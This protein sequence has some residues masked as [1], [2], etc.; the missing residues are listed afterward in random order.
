M[1]NPCPFKPSEFKALIPNGSQPFC[2]IFRNFLKLFTLIWQFF[3][4]MVSEDGGPTQDFLVWIGVPATNEYEES[5]VPAAVMSLDASDSYEGCIRLTWRN[6]F[7]ATYFRVKRGTTNVADDATEIAGWAE[8]KDTFVDSEAI[9]SFF[10]ETDYYYWVQVKNAAGESPWSESALGSALE[11]STDMVGITNGKTIVQLAIQT[12][13]VIDFV[14]WGGGGAGGAGT[15]DVTEHYYSATITRLFKTP[16]TGGSGASGGYGYVR[17][18]AVSA[19]DVI[20][21]KRGL[22]GSP[23]EGVGGLNGGIGGNTEFQIHRS[24]EPTTKTM[25]VIS[26]GGGGEATIADKS[27]NRVDIALLGEGGS[28]FDNQTP[29]GSFSCQKGSVGNNGLIGTNAVCAGAPAI[30]DT[31]FNTGAYGA[32]GASLGGNLKPSYGENGMVFYA[33]RGGATA[34]PTE[35]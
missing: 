10:A 22:G 12:D 27:T 1:A 29:Y 17:S 34:I 4:W 24:G 7:N 18:F 11:V 16:V 14:G 28:A 23:Y 26:G 35:S 25:V 8:I 30:V 5:Q 31:I 6:P 33:L 9:G 21:L 19:G 32:G 15:Y 3:K 13:G 20:T 2:T